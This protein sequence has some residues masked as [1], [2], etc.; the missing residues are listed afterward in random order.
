MKTTTIH[1]GGPD[2]Y[3]EKTKRLLD[4]RFDQVID[5]IYFSHQPIYGYRSHYSAEANIGRHMITRSILN[6]LNNY[7]FKSFI[8]I[9]GA[10][11]YTANLV[12]NLFG[13]EVMST[14][15]SESACQRAKEIFGIEAVA[16]DIHQLPFADAS[17]DAVLCSET[18][19]HVTDFKKAVT[20]LLRITKKVLVITVPHESA[21]Q[22]EFN[23]RDNV[24]HGHINYFDV[25]SFNYLQ[26]KGYTVKWERTQ[27]PF[28]VIPRVL[29]EASQK[30]GTNLAIGLYNIFRPILRK[31]FGIKTAKG[32]VNIDAKL[33][34]ITGPYMGISFVIEKDLSAA[35]EQLARP[36]TA[37]DF[38]NLTVPHHYLTY[39]NRSHPNFSGS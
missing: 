3:T 24:P 34:R 38:V 8:D 7:S 9:G 28:L 17:F 12:K 37:N 32:L 35:R 10:E 1:S 2:A 6:Q 26:E 27:S 13:A 18:I 22:V 29:A 25:N 36:I 4:D 5:G 39:P 11:G 16:C 30:S 23:I 21:E 31:L 15:L 33:C 14:D 19:E 20:E